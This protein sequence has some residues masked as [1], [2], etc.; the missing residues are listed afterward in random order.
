MILLLSIGRK[1]FCGL[2][3]R[4]MS[5]LGI[6]YQQGAPTQTAKRFAGYDISYDLVPWI[7]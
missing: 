6:Y 3:H 5:L 1:L 4:R 7:L 2:A